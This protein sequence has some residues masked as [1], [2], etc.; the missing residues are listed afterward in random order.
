MIT[1]LRSDDNFDDLALMNG[2]G[3]GEFEPVQPLS[4]R[5]KYFSAQPWDSWQLH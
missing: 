1:D 5:L 4:N 3:K 2:D